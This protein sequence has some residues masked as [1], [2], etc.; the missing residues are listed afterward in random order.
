MRCLTATERGMTA[1][2]IIAAH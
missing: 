2:V 1:P